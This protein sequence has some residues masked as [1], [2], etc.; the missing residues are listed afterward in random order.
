LSAAAITLLLLLGGVPGYLGTVFLVRGGLGSLAAGTVLLVIAVLLPFA[1]GYVFGLGVVGA[2]LG[3]AAGAVWVGRR[4]PWRRRIAAAAAVVA[5]VAAPLLLMTASEISAD[6]GFDRCAADRAVAILASARASEG[7][8]PL[9]VSD[10]GF[11]DRGPYQGPCYASN[12]VN[13]LYRSDGISYTIGYWV[14]WHLARRVCV[15]Q[16]RPA[17]LELLVRAVGSIPPGRGGLVN[18]LYEAES[19]T[20]PPGPLVRARRR[21]SR[22]GRRRRPGCR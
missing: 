18:S 21:R 3:S 5:V 14:D 12:G 8:Y 2:G 22:P 11:L 19:I 1:Y 6:E 16:L 9:E 10:V 20:L 7:R 15:P 17:G 4:S 13:W